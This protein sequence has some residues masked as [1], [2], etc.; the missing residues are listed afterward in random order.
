MRKQLDP[1]SRLLLVGEQM[2]NVCFSLSQRTNIEPRERQVMRELCS[3]WDHARRQH[4]VLT[5]TRKK[6]KAK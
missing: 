3:D 4:A 5:K 1:L 2:S 6:A